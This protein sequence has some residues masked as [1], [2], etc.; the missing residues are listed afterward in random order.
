MGDRK[1]KWLNYPEKTIP[2]LNKYRTILKTCK[3]IENKSSLQENAMEQQG[4]DSSD[5]LLLTR[6]SE[7]AALSFFPFS[8]LQK[9]YSI[10]EKGSECEEMI[11]ASILWR[12]SEQFLS[13]IIKY[14]G[15]KTGEN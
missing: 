7:W 12:Y 9:V 6:L 13:S 11:N 3:Y 1:T 5:L 8:T 14:V 2:R 4:R 15:F 10:D